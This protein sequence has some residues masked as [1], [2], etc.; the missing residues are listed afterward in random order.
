MFPCAYL[1]GITSIIN[2]PTV[3]VQGICSSITSNPCSNCPLHSCTN[4]RRRRCL[5]SPPEIAVLAV[6][7]PKCRS[8]NSGVNR[9]TTSSRRSNCSRTTM[10]GT[11]LMAAITTAPTTLTT[12]ATVATT[13]AAQRATLRTTNATGCTHQS[14]SSTD[15]LCIQSR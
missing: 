5:I 7:R 8:L 11:I 4:C 10:K 15:T 1:R 2:I 13:T 9:T 6:K 3:L 12:T 14:S